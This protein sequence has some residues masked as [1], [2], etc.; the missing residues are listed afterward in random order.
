[1]TIRTVTKSIAAS[2]VLLSGFSLAALPASAGSG[3]FG[4]QCALGHALGKVVDTP[5]KVTWESDAGK[6]YCF[7]NEEAKTIFL[8]DPK[9][10][11]AKAEAN[12]SKVKAN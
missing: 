2:A 11:L 1:M 4:G 7:G 6:T 10:N 8:K 12:Y 9:Q 3:E 5:C